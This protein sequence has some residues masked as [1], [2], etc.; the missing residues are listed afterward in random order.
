MALLDSRNSIRKRF[1]QPP[2]HHEDQHVYKAVD[3]TLS[4]LYASN[5]PGSM[6]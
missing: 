1:S 5:H 4:S 6:R 2:K 3:P